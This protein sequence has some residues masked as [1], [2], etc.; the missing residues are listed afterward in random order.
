[1]FKQR[2][3]K[4]KPPSTAPVRENLESLAV[5][6]ALAI[7]LKFFAVE[8]YK[9]P[10]PSM[11]PTLMG[12]REAGIYDRLLVDKTAFLAR[13]PRRWEIAVFKYPMHRA[14]NYIKRIWGLPGEWLTTGRG[15]VWQGRE[16]AYPPKKPAMRPA[17][18]IRK[19]AALQEHLWLT[20]F[21]SK[22]VPSR[23]HRV[24]EGT[25]QA[26]CHRREGRCLLEVKEAGGMVR[27]FQRV[28][29]SPDHGYPDKAD[30]LIA[31]ELIGGG[32]VQI[33]RAHV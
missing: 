4:P 13:A 15:D 33:G 24:L 14:Q 18:V 26:S 28:I 7:F 20:V 3:K 16:G 2:K 31:T 19:P 17:T 29:A 6:V 30:R 25:G 32:G 12:D 9:I 1:M 21:D 8:A 5:A 22:R 23:L 27:Y 10:T 11:Q